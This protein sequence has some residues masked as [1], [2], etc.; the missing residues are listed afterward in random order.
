M[1]FITSSLEFQVTTSVINLKDI[2]KPW[3]K[4]HQDLWI[5]FFLSEIRMVVWDTKIWSFRGLKGFLTLIFSSHSEFLTCSPRTTSLYQNLNSFS[6]KS[7]YFHLT[8]KQ[9]HLQ[10]HCQN[11]A[12]YFLL[13]PFCLFFNYLMNYFLKHL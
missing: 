4:C 7:H 8:P 2:K 10:N 11:L 9:Y 12:Y 6:M 13:N 1:S 3:P 5:M